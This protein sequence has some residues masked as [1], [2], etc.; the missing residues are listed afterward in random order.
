MNI[1]D[2]DSKK[3]D[4]IITYTPNQFPIIVRLFIPQDHFINMS[5]HSGQMVIKIPFRKDLTS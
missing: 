4:H 5:I 2:N 3:L 1:I